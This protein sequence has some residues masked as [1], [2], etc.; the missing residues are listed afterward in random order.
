MESL[1]VYKQHILRPAIVPHKEGKVT[2]ID[3]TIYKYVCLCKFRSCE[4]QGDNYIIKCKENTYKLLNYRSLNTATILRRR[5][6]FE[7]FPSIEDKVKEYSC[8]ELIDTTFTLRIP[9]TEMLE[10][11]KINTFPYADECIIVYLSSLIKHDFDMQYIHLKSVI[12]VAVDK[13]LWE[14]YDDR[15]WY[16]DQ[17]LSQREY[18]IGNVPYSK[19][20]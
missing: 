2:I 1:K 10:K 5:L 3:C 7:N 17:Y 14:E 12:L 19:V 9:T 4:K 16:W 18:T 13:P 8:K 15:C 6:I 20:I 11:I